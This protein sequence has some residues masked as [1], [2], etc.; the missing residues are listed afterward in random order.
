MGGSSVFYA[1]ALER[2]EP[3]D[4]DADEDIDHPTGGW[5]VGYDA[6]RPYLDEAEDLL[7]VRGD[8]DPL[9]DI[10]MPKLRPPPERSAAEAAMMAEF[11]GRD[12]EPTGDAGDAGDDGG[13]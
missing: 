10:P 3:H 1:A 12:P 6:F 11:E 7:W 4:L 2:P 9:S 8:P 5:P 13:R